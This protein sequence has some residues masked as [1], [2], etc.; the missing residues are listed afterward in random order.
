MPHYT[1]ESMSDHPQLVLVEWEDSMSFDP[2]M[3]S[4][5]IVE[6]FEQLKLMRTVG[7]LIKETK[8]GIILGASH[9]QT[10]DKF[11]SSWLIPHSQIVNLWE[12][13]F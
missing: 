13:D 7:F 8:Q 1:Q 5:E 2:W 4:H 10:F 3:E 9:E 6:A 12:I 11:A